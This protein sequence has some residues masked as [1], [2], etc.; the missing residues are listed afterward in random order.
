[1]DQKTTYRVLTTNEDGITSMMT[2]S[3]N[4]TKMTAFEFMTEMQRAGFY[5]AG[6]NWNKAQRHELQ[7]QPKFSGFVGPM[8]DGDALRYE[9]HETYNRMSI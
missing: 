8:W 1:M 6:E 2:F 5:Y 9:C 3:K 7:G 4:Q